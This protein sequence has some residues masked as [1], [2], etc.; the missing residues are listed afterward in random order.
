MCVCAMCVCSVCSCCVCYV[1][2]VCLVCAVC[3]VCAVLCSCVRMH[4]NFRV[5]KPPCTHM[6]CTWSAHFV[7]ISNVCIACYLPF[8]DSDFCWFCVFVA[9]CGIGPISLNTL[10]DIITWPSLVHTRQHGVGLGVNGGTRARG[11]GAGAGAGGGGGDGGSPRGGR[12]GLGAGMAN[13]TTP[14]AGSRGG[15]RGGA[16]AGAGAGGGTMGSGS[17]GGEG[18]GG[19]GVSTGDSGGDVRQMAVRLVKKLLE[20]RED[21]CYSSLSSQNTSVGLAGNGQSPVRVCY[22]CTCMYVCICFTCTYGCLRVH[23]CMV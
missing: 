18:R 4:S 8:A 15:M 12:T 2:A 13:E 17:G 16:G 22:V 19:A 10:V 3:A 14:A 5:S 11:R 23:A 21:V 20:R 1:C 7:C 9:W 6:L